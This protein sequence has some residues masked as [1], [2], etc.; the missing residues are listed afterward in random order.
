MSVFS[1]PLE[2]TVNWRPALDPCGQVE[3]ALESIHKTLY[4]EIFGLRAVF[5]GECS[6]VWLAAQLKEAMTQ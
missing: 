5:T 2:E 3:E 1:R 4:F 6:D